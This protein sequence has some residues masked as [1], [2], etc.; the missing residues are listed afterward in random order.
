MLPSSRCRTAE[1][2]AA[3]ENR[4][5]ALICPIPLGWS[6]LSVATLRHGRT[7]ET[8]AGGTTSPD[9]WF[10]RPHSCVENAI[11][12]SPVRQL[13]A[14]RYH[15]D[16]PWDAESTATPSWDDVVTAI[17]RMDDHFFPIVQLNCG[18]HDD[19][20]A[21]FNVIG[22]NGQAI[23]DNST[24]TGAFAVQDSDNGTSDNRWRLVRNP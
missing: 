13:T 15:R 17:R 18:E 23:Q 4:L 19:D 16:R 21:I 24:A 6:D 14:I 20:E 2:R 12:A 22:G 10:R 1:T 11:V 7:G 5:D 9:D 8:V 3:C